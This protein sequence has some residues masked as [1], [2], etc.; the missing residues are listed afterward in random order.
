MIIYDK[1]SKE[2]FD[3]YLMDNGTLDTVLKVYSF[4]GNDSIE[5]SFDCEYASQFRKKSGEL[6]IKGFKN[7][8][9]EAI[10]YYFESKIN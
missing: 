7:L 8:A 5:C 2:R 1:M 9:K 6:T 10:D 4:L 3:V